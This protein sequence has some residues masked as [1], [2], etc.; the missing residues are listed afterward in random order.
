MRRIGLAIVAALSLTVAGCSTADSVDGEAIPASEVGSSTTTT[1]ASASPSSPTPGSESPV[2]GFKATFRA[3]TGSLPNGTNW[4]LSLPQVEAGAPG[5]RA[6]FNAQMDS[7]LTKLTGSATTDYPFTFTDGSLTPTEKSRAVVGSRVLSGAVITLSSAPR[8][9]HPNTN[10]ETVVLDIASTKPITDPYVDPA[11]AKS[12][13]GPLAIAAD[14][15]HRLSA[16]D[17]G[18]EDFKLWIPLPEGFHVYVSV[19][20]A[21][22]DYVAV[23]IPWDKVTPILK[24]EVA[25]AVSP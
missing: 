16:I 17:V 1:P 12:V 22:G 10:V 8:A 23:T 18:Y 9:A 21:L 5:P 14:P 19:S 2:P 13:L 3:A 6:A 24:P 7:I 25:H 15:T 20:H 11:R 4:N